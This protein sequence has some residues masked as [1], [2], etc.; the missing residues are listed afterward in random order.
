M[1]RRV[2]LT[3]GLLS[4]ALAGPG[5]ANDRVDQIVLALQG[6]GY[7]RIEIGRTWLGRTR[8]VATG[9]QGTREIVIQPSTGE[10]LRDVQSEDDSSGRGR[11]RGGDDDA[12]DDSDDDDDDSDD[13]DDD[14]SDDGDDDSDDGDDDSD[15]ADDSSDDDDGGQGRGR[16]R[17][18]DDE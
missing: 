5:M 3:A 7:S 13:S 10:V 17:G 14:D 12:D 6:E 16:G 2:F 18:G 15:D 11:G 1:N 8:I 4:L 9:E